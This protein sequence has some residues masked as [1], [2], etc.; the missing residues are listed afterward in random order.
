MSSRISAVR[1]S[2]GSVDYTFNTTSS[3]ITIY[4]DAEMS[5]QALDELC[6]DL[7]DF[8]SQNG[9]VIVNAIVDRDGVCTSCSG[10]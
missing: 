6:R 7:S 9:L 2:D 1:M 3:E 8:A 5:R 4:A 10:I